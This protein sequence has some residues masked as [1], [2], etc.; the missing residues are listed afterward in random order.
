VHLAWRQIAPGSKASQYL[1]THREELSPRTCSWEDFKRAM[2]DACGSRDTRDEVN[3]AKWAAMKWRGTALATLRELQSVE[4]LLSYTMPET[5]KLQHFRSLTPL[6]LKATLVGASCPTARDEFVSAVD[7]ILAQQK[8]NAASA[9]ND[10]S[11]APLKGNAEKK[12]AKNTKSQGHKGK[13]TRRGSDTPSA[14]G[15]TKAKKSSWAKRRNEDEKAG[16]CFN[17]HKP[18]HV[19][20]DCPS[21]GKAAMR[22]TKTTELGESKGGSGKGQAS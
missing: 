21:K 10:S 16:H 5:L 8:A 13:R 7:Q 2:L 14:D 22:S 17:C 9:K 6:N 19:S 11:N 1:E 12:G 20:R 4:R 18:G 15:D 3:Y